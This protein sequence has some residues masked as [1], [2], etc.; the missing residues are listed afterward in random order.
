MVGIEA[1]PQRCEEMD[2]DA[3]QL[4]KYI[5]DHVVN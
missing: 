5:A 2:A 4:K 1:L 3:S